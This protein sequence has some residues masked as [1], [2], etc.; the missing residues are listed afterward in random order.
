GPAE[1]LHP[2]R[3]RPAPFQ[4]ERDL[5][6]RI[7]R[8]H[9]R[10]PTQTRAELSACRSPCSGRSRSAPARGRCSRSAV[11]GAAGGCVVRCW[12]PATLG[13]GLIR[14]A[15]PPG[16]LVPASQLIDG[17]WPDQPP[18]GAPN[19]LQALVSRLRRALPEAVI[20]VGPAG[21]RLAIKP[22]DTDIVR[23]EDLAA[24]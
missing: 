1:G 13:R 23:F 21:Y 8:I 9:V 4:L 10:T 18:A 24:A 7:N 14:L 19:A 22:Q 12:G 2:V 17:L 16:Q 11:R 3:R 6:Q 20:E 15:L 5:S